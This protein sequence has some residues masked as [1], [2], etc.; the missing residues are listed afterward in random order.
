[1]TD[2]LDNELVRKYFGCGPLTACCGN[3]DGGMPVEHMSYRILR[4]M[5]Q[6]IK[7]GER[8][9]VGTH[10]DTD[11][12]GVVEKTWE[13]TDIRGWHTA[14]LRLPDRFQKQENPTHVCP[15]CRAIHP[16]LDNDGSQPKPSPEK[17]GCPPAAIL[18]WG[19]ICM[20]VD[21][22]EEKIQALT[23]KWRVIEWSNPDRAPFV[24]MQ[25]LRDLVAL[26]RKP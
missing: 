20:A 4:A 6:P 3:L 16:V 14:Y 10:Q 5:Q 8:Y 7:K 18:Q 11:M 12:W 23:D 2:L 13:G 22:V 24:L 26:A 9:L 1:M 21:P 25:D 19:H 17:C 15:E